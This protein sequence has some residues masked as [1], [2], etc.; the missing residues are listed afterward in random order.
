M[1]LL[2]TKYVYSS[3]RAD[4]ILGPEGRLARKPARLDRF[5][6]LVASIDARTADAPV[7]RKRGVAAAS[8]SRKIA[9]HD[10]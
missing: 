3:A 9:K 6:K 7:K 4:S 5:R 10:D 1:K 8:S 2:G